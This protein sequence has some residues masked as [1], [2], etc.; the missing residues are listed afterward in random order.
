M[1]AAR[2]R[3]PSNPASSAPPPLAE[4]PSPMLPARVKLRMSMLLEGVSAGVEV[5]AGEGDGE[6]PL[7]PAPP[8]LA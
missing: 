4:P 6:G 2:L 1:D 3:V 7:P 8:P 5:P